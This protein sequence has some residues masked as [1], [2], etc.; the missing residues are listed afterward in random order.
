MQDKA[1]PFYLDSFD[2]KSLKGPINP[3]D[4]SPDLPPH[5]NCDAGWQ[6]NA[7][8]M[9]CYY[10]DTSEENVHNLDFNM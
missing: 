7:A 6:Y 5:V 1:G 3:P 9:K 10:L 2:C 4:E 8:A